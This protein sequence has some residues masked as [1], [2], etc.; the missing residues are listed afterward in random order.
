MTDWRDLLAEQVR[1]LEAEA[2][3]PALTPKALAMLAVIRG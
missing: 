1:E 3:N 2:G